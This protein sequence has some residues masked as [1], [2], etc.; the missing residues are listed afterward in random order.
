MPVRG[1][2][3][4]WKSLLLGAAALVVLAVPAGSQPMAASPHGEILWDTYG[5]PHVFGK[6]EAGVLYGFGWAQVKSHANLV[7]RLYGQ[8][9]GRAAEYWGDI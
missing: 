5:V 7:L 1:H 9:Q 6:D 4:T 3:A 2:S 8:A